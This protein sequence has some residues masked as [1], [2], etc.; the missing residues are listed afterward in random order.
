MLMAAVYGCLHM[1]ITCRDGGNSVPCATRRRNPSRRGRRGGRRKRRSL[2]A[3]APDVPPRP[4]RRVERVERGNGSRTRHFF[5]AFNRSVDRALPLSA[6]IADIKSRAES[7]RQLGR[8]PLP[9]RAAEGLR[10]RQ[11][12]LRAI[13][14]RWG[15]YH[16]RVTGGSAPRGRQYWRSQLFSRVRDRGGRQDLG[17]LMG[18]E[19]TTQDYL[20]TAEEFN[21]PG[22]TLMSAER[23]AEEVE[24]ARLRA[25]MLAHLESARRPY[26]PRFSH[27]RGSSP[28]SP[29]QAAVAARL[30]A[31]G[32]SRRGRRG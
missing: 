8:V 18:S 16:D 7:R 28:L 11:N 12:R 14:I 21:P 20:H 17:T 13:S 4:P 10:I 24:G 19:V 1:R 15:G 9:P 29:L 5:T 2:T 27:R 32:A 22:R 31:R 30:A 25:V 23:F 26:R 3:A 6:Q